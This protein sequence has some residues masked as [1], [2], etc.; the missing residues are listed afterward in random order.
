MSLAG[1]SWGLGGGGGAATAPFLIQNCCQHISE[2]W[3]D[4]LA[5]NETFRISLLASL[6]ALFSY[7]LISTIEIW[8]SFLFYFGNFGSSLFKSFSKSSCPIQNGI[9]LPLIFLLLLNNFLLSYAHFFLNLR[10]SKYYDIPNKTVCPQ[11]HIYSQLAFYNGSLDI[12]T[13]T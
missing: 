8:W 10:I 5:T 13:I 11:K 12:P 7:P 9:T 3:F 2:F 1:T 6:F 4:P